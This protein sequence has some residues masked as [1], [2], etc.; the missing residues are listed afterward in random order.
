[1]IDFEGF[2][3]QLL[4]QV[5]SLLPEWLPGGRFDHGEYKC[6]DISGGGGGSLCVDL[7]TGRWLD[8]GNDA[9]KGG[10]LV[11][12]YAT[13]HGLEQRVAA[14]SLG[15]E[16][17]PNGNG[18][19]L[20]T[21]IRPDEL[22]D[23]P[24]HTAEFKHSKHGIPSQFWVY[25]SA[26]GAPLFVVA[27]YDT[28]KGKEIVP[29]TWA[30]RWTAKGYAK[31]RP[32]YGLE[33]LAAIDGPILIVEG[34]KTADAAQQIFP[35]NP[36]LT[37]CGGASAVKTADWSPIAVRQVILWPDN[38]APGKAAMATVG[39]LM[40]EAGCSV[41]I[42][43]PSGWPEGWDVADALPADDVSAYA[44]SHLKPIEKPAAVTPTAR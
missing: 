44:E 27:R 40:L 14:L 5:E 22:P 9:H 8:F 29:W 26:A 23:E 10:D 34:E 24:Y 21:R 2:N 32:L 4:A 18:A 39:A 20:P 30:R 16:D 28:D 17:K 36:C 13:I 33:R 6:S 19:H 37:W 15:A 42:V 41:Q 11:S 12:L 7:K 3:S 31:P 38:D 43:D 25:R 35:N 1:M